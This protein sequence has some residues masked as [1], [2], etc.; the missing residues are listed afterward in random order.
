LGD[1]DFG[2]RR[3]N[4]VKAVELRCA[5]PF[6]EYPA[7]RRRVPVKTL[8]GL[9]DEWT[10]IGHRTNQRRETAQFMS[11]VQKNATT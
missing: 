1:K 4:G 10:I 2:K 8:D 7:S 11:K 6:A 9:L 3:V 5:R